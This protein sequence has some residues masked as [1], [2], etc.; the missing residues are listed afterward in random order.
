MG[1][2]ARSL[3]RSSVSR[4][5]TAPAFPREPHVTLL[6]V[7]RHQRRQ[8]VEREPG[9]LPLT[10]HGISPPSTLRLCTW[11]AKPRRPDVSGPPTPG[12]SRRSRCRRSHGRSHK[13]RRRGCRSTRPRRRGPPP[14][15]SP[16][17]RCLQRR[18]SRSSSRPSDC[19]PTAACSRVPKALTAK[20]RRRLARIRRTV[21]RD[22]LAGPAV[23]ASACSSARCRVRSWTPEAVSSLKRRGRPTRDRSSSSTSAPRWRSAAGAAR[24]RSSRRR[25]A[26]IAG[27]RAGS[28][29]DLGPRRGPVRERQN[30]QR[31]GR[32]RI[33]VHI[34]SKTETG[35]AKG[36]W[37]SGPIAPIMDP[38]WAVDRPRPLDRADASDGPPGDPMAEH[39]TR[40]S[41]RLG[42]R[43]LREKPM[44]EYVSSLMA[45]VK[46][47]N[48]A[49]PEFHQA[50]QEV[51]S[52][53]RSCST[54]TPST[55]TRRSSSASS[56]PSA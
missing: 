47:K 18:A 36:S 9:D 7:D 55:G 42:G 40:R 15:G 22:G 46:A 53:S 14:A 1:A 51:A 54:A 2:P 20:A 34:I 13:P 41:D 6:E 45:E 37:Q 52:R 23:A 16:P 12:R 27:Q 31:L 11:L 33:H 3:R 19:G 38:I 28:L 30:Q 5:T 32:Q 17:A 35:S 48:P 26:R 10:H 50:V 44:N 21:P 25:A 24:G 29:G 8:D 43:F 4:S 56:S 49:E 39:S